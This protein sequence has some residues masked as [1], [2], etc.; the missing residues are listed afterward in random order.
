MSQRLVKL[1]S[2]LCVAPAFALPN[3]TAL[4]ANH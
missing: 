3:E 2:K 1:A 4:P